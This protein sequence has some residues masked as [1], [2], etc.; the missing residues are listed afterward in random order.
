MSGQVTGEAIA[1]EGDRDGGGGERL[2]S[3][4]LPSPGARGRDPAAATR[5]G[6]VP[7]WRLLLGGR[8]GRRYI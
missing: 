5:D 8:P 4:R 3:A 6:V 2:P 1:A 7:G